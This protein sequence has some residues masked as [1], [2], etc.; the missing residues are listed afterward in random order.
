MGGEISPAK[1]FW[2]FYCIYTWLIFIPFIYFTQEIPQP[3]KTTWIVFSAWFWLRGI[4]EMVM[5]FIT[6]NWTPPIGIAHDLSCV[7][8]LMFMPMFFKHTL[9]PLHSPFFIFHMSLIFGA[10]M[11]TY[12]AMTFHKIVGEKTK[13]DEAVWYANKEDPVFKRVVFITA[14]ANFPIYGGLLFIT[15]HLASR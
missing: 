1:S 7:L 4:V 12:Y 9:G 13:G 6:K 5:M 10:L 11:E 2:L 14:L 15:H 8:L 3:Y